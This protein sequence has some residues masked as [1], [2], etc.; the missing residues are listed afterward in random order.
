MTTATEDR[1]IFGG[2]KFKY[3]FE[4]NNSGTLKSTYMDAPKK[5]DDTRAIHEFEKDQILDTYNISF[6]FSY[7]NL[8]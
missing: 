2:G 3:T 5:E 4:Y 7:P 6:G 1:G 8:Q